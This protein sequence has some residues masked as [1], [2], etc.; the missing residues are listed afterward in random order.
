MAVVFS[1][2]KRGIF[3]PAWDVTDTAI[4]YKK[5]IIPFSCIIDAEMYCGSNG[6]FDIKTSG[7]SYSIMFNKADWDNAEKAYQYVMEHI[8]QKAKQETQLPENPIHLLALKCGCSESKA[9]FAVV[10]FEYIAKILHS[11]EN[12]L[13]CIATGPVYERETQNSVGNAAVVVTNKRIIIAGETSDLIKTASSMSVDLQHV[14]SI[15]IEAGIIAYTLYISTA[16]K[17]IECTYAATKVDGSEEYLQGFANAVYAAKKEKVQKDTTSIPNSA[18]DEIKKF[19]ELLDMG[20][21]T[22]EEFDTKKKQLL[23]L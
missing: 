2:P 12:A 8:P 23:G 4:E 14:D 19:K 17:Q 16:G 13:Y 15:N 18:A 1:F 21:I 5:N 10:G 7:K 3:F 20:I 11:D 9:D 6:V 22:Q